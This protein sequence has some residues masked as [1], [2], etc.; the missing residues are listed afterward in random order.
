MSQTTSPVD[1]AAAVRPE[2]EY[3]PAP[4]QP[5]PVVAVPTP[6]PASA[7][8]AAPTTVAPTA[9]P[10]SAP[11][12]PVLSLN[13]AL[14]RI[15]ATTHQVELLGA[16]AADERRAGNARDTVANYRARLAAFAARPA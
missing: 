6:A 3:V 8:V 5:A 9:T 15:S 12:A 14:A 2:P 10:A 1:P 16:F 13:D 11:A 4:R 7:P